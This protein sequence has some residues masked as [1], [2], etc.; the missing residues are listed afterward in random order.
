MASGNPENPGFWGGANFLIGPRIGACDTP[1]ASLVRRSDCTGLADEVLQVSGFMASGNPENPGFWGGANFLIGPRIGACDTPIA[2]SR[3]A[4]S[5]FLKLCVAINVIRNVCAAGGGETEDKL[6]KRN[7]NGKTPLYQAVYAGQKHK[8]QFWLE[9]G[10]DPT[11]PDNDG[12]TPLQLVIEKKKKTIEEQE[13]AKGK[14][15]NMLEERCENF[16]A[17]ENLLREYESKFSQRSDV[18][19]HNDIPEIQ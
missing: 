15:K 2:S 7:K 18:K 8:V 14:R 5:N 12:K 13:K 10:A 4:F 3:Q 11:I 9:L 19:D 6:N 1:I 16:V 17:I